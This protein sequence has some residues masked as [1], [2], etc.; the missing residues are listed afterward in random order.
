MAQGFW[1]RITKALSKKEKN[2]AVVCDASDLNF[3]ESKM[4]RHALQVAKVLHENGHPA[5]LVGGCVRDVLLGKQP[6]DFDVAT[7]AHPGTIRALFRNSRIIGR[8]F[9]LVHIYFR[10]EIIEVSTFRG[11]HDDQEG[12][13]L[14]MV[15]RDNQFGSL[16]EDAWRRDLSINSLYYDPSSRKILDFT[17]GLLDINKRTLRMIGD[18]KQRFHEDPVRMLRAIRFQAKLGF[19]ME[20]NMASEIRCL[21]DLLMQVPSGRLFDENLKFFYTGH[22]RA[23]YDAL[24]HFGCFTLLYPEIDKVLQSG[25]LDPSY[26]KFLD[27]AMKSTDRRIQQNLGVNPGFLLAVMLWAPFQFHLL[28]FRDDELADNM[29]LKQVMQRVI[30]TQ[31]EVLKIPK[32]FS[33]MIQDIWFFTIPDDAWFAAF[34]TWGGGPPFFSCSGGFF[35]VS[36]G[37]GRAF[38]IPRHMVARV[39]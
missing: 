1:E 29:A 30:K 34:G 11:K 33:F 4:S 22:A 31:I 12:D 39:L 26:Q 37:S 25:E 8:R 5:Y 32:R 10:D 21:G 3:D 15:V 16:E 24:R 9:Q 28:A 6:K 2:A 14:K 18:V 20:A 23:S 17:G 13:P 35:G 36:C 7:E 38:R 27:V 19:K